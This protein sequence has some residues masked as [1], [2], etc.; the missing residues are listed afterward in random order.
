MLGFH[1]LTTF[2]SHAN[3]DECN[4]GN[5]HERYAQTVQVS[6]HSS[7]AKRMNPIMRVRSSRDPGKAPSEEGGMSMVGNIC[8][9]HTHQQTITP[10]HLVCGNKCRFDRFYKC[11]ARTGAR[12][13]RS[14]GGP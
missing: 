3:K 12:R 8:R 5:N 11:V 13:R 10:L 9:M 6:A 2:K 7:N 4:P 1:K 14:G